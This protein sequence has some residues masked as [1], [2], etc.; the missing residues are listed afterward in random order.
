MWITELFF[1]EKD[2]GFGIIAGVP[3]IVLGVFFILEGIGKNRGIALKSNEKW[4]T[5]LQVFHFNLYHP[6]YIDN[7]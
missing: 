4:K 5:S 3:L 2:G 7:N 6:I 1:V